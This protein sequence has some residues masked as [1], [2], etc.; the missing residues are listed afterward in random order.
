M[1][2]P[3]A[4][5]KRRF[6]EASSFYH[7]VGSSL[8]TRIFGSIPLLPYSVSKPWL[9]NFRVRLFSVTVRTS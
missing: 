9:S 2:L 3:N 7:L 6:F 1:N 8:C 4:A 5:L